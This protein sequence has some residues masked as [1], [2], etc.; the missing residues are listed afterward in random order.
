M[1]KKISFAF[2]AAVVAVS[3][4]FAAGNTMLVVP[5]R[6]D[7]VNLEFDLLRRLP[8]NLEIACFKGDDAVERLEV[9]NKAAHSWTTVSLDDWAAGAYRAD[10]LVLAGESAAAA[11]LLKQ[12]SWA[13]QIQTPTDRKA[14]EI[15]KAVDSCQKLSSA[16]WRSL[17]ETYGFT[18]TTVKP[19]SR[20]DRGEAMKAAR[21]E[22]KAAE[23]AAKAEAE[24]KAA[25]LKA[26][27]RAEAARKAAEQKTAAQT[28]ITELPPEPEVKPLPVLKSED[29]T[30]PDPLAEKVV[31]AE[32]YE[33]LAKAEAEK[34]SAEL[35]A[36]EDAAK[37][38][39]EKKAAELKAAEEAAKAEAE[40]KAA[41]LKA[42]EEAAKAEA[43][44]KAAEL[45]AAEDAAKAEAE[46]KAAE[47][48]A[49]EEAAKAEAEAKVKDTVKAAVTDAVAR[50]KAE[51]DLSASDIKVASPVTGNEIK[52]STKDILL[53]K[54]AD[55]EVKTPAVAVPAVEVKA[56]E[57]KAPEVAV[58]AVEV[59]A[60]EVK[61]PA[62]VLDPL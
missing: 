13:K 23:R 8:K 20:Y 62:V 42:A 61:A 45:K 55:P 27:A 39:A 35:K 17:S 56:P 25:E 48:K 32:E 5:A 4:V 10:S 41:E 34:K 1:N 43:E 28:T 29:K 12:S 44:K 37:A 14:L 50:P 47:L 31:S 7:M 49:A 51:G 54:P 16:Q 33:A 58:P 60:P 18:F 15:V 36:A 21:A 59:K 24:R 52:V 19:E 40:K 46:K 57:V 26:A 30:L 2:A 53:T 11:S 38:E 6:H 9:F 22:K 3:G